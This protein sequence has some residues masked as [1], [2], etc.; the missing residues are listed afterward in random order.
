MKQQPERDRKRASVCVIALV[1]LRALRSRASAAALAP[2]RTH[3]LK[4]A[5]ESFLTTSVTALPAA[6]AALPLPLPAASTTTPGSEDSEPG[7]SGLALA[8]LKV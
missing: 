8:L 7:L 2:R 3:S 1:S 5:V 6:S 4:V